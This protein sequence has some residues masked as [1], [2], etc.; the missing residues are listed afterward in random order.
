[1]GIVL[2][3]INAILPMQDFNI[4]LFPFKESIASIKPYVEAAKDFKNV[5]LLLLSLAGLS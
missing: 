5:F 3:I 4:A 1:V 2:G